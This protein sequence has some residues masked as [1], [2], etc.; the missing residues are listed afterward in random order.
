MNIIT[1]NHENLIEEHICCALDS[2][3]SAIGIAEKKEWLKNRINEGLKFKKLDARGKVFIEYIPVEMG[4][5]PIEAKGYMLI[6]CHWVSGSYKGKGYG[7][8]L[9]K[10]CENEAK[11][12]GM[13][14]IVI[15]TANKKKPFLSD[16]S[17]YLKSG[18]E[19]VDSAPPYFELIAKRFDNR[20]E[21]P[22]FADSAKRGFPEE[23]K[24]ID[25]FYTAQCP[26]TVPYIELLKPII[27]SSD[28]PVR[29]H[30]IKSREEAQNH[31]CP[32][33][34]YSV[35]IDGKFHTQEILTPT[36]LKQLITKL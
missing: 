32:A 3:T 36:K 5:L 21:L 35:F 10:E 33:T 7:S 27:L 26:F 34:T 15:L 19:T 8:E 31:F 14:G 13:K 23:I 18:Y 25:I 22:K 6:N 29:T 9:L 12:S 16:K 20:A 4:W 28:V 1:L 2:K 24:G 11:S 30:Q 17:F